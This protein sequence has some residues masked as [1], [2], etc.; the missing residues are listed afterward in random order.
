MAKK[1]KKGKKKAKGGEEG[2]GGE[3]SYK[4]GKDEP[5]SVA[6]SILSFQI[7][8]K[9]KTIEAFRDEIVQLKVENEESKEK[10]QKLQAQQLQYVKQSMRAAKEFDSD[11]Q[12]TL[13]ELQTKIETALK[14][15]QV[16][17]QKLQAEEAELKGKCDA[18]QARTDET[19]QEKAELIDYKDNGSVLHKKNI[20]ILKCAIK[21]I[22]DSFDE[23]AKYIQKNLR[24]TLDEISKDTASKVDS[25]KYQATD[26]AIQLLDP[27]NYTVAQQ[28]SWLKSEVQ[29]LRN[30]IERLWKE[31]EK[32]ETDNIFMLTD[33][34][35]ERMMDIKRSR[36][37]YMDCVKKGTTFGNRTTLLITP[38]PIED[39]R[40][41]IEDVDAKDKGEEDGDSEEGDDEFTDDSDKEMGVTDAELQLLSIQ[42]VNKPLY[43]R[44]SDVEDDSCLVAVSSFEWTLDDK[45]P[46]SLT[47]L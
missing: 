35:D 22:N 19:L 33:M 34:Y 29:L 18:E 24:L 21:D 41:A 10:T 39:E 27:R 17:T 3:V 4:P 30:D 42:G 28:N 7:E 20:D 32:L 38:P 13:T 8:V 11:Y 44:P 14:E 2:S 1:G 25:Q 9:T 12:N 26:R 40:L 31:V 6:E 45:I 16:S 15:K 46:I 43:E 23:N 47:T 5:L 37:H 36:Q